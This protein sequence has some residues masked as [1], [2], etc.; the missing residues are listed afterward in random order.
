[1]SCALDLLERRNRSSIF[2]GAASQPNDQKKKDAGL[3]AGATSAEIGPR[4]E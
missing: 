4:R 2:P 1:M 3:K